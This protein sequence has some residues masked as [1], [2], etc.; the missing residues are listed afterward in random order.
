[1]QLVKLAILFVEGVMAIHV[2]LR[3][4]GANPAAGF[5]RFIDTL[6]APFIGPFRPV[7]TDQLV[8]GH[9]LEVGSLLGMAV[10]AILAFVAIRVIRGVFSPGHL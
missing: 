6:S 10:Y 5:S 4:A 9:P 8:N 1:V 7:F 2:V 3:V